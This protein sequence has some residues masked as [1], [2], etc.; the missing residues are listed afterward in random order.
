[1]TTNDLCLSGICLVVKYF[2]NSG[3][4]ENRVILTEA[5]GH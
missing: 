1:M 3:E 5:G 2:V 4:K